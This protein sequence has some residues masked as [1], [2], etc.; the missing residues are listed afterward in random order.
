MH[1]WVKS[2]WV[3]TRDFSG[4]RICADASYKSPCWAYPT[5]TCPALSISTVFS[6][7]YS[8]APC[9]RVGVSG[10]A[11]DLNFGLSLH[12]HPYFVCASSEGSGESAHV[13]RLA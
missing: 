9:K 7:V 3:S 10:K 11:R 6:F 12:L 13:R 4:Y 5:L 2:I 8:K 1:Q